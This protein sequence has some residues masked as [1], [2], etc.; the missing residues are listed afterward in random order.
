MAKRPGRQS[1]YNYTVVVP[2]W[3][4]NSCVISYRVGAGLAPA[5]VRASYGRG[6]PPPWLALRL[7]YGRRKP[8]PGSRL[9]QSIGGSVPILA[10]ALM[11][12]GLI[13]EN[14]TGVLN[15]E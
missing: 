12:T 7:G 3:H 10:R 14:T 2:M 5:L 13:S 8:R 4:N 15:N 9:I 6:L 11:K 1:A